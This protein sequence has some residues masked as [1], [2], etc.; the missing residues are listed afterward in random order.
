[1]TSKKLIIII[2]VI[3]IVASL[4]FNGYFGWE[5]VK[6]DIYQKGLVDGGNN[7][8]QQIKN[9][10]NITFEDGVITFIKKQ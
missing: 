3:L 4:S 1:M 2:G 10:V 5:K 6:A 8:V 7:V 9:G